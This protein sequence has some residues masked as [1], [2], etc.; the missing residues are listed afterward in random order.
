[1]N[2]NSKELLTETPFK[3]MLKLSVPAIIGMMVIGLYPLMDGIFAGQLLGQD[4]MTAIGVSMPFTYFNTG[5]ATLI[6]VGSS[7]ILSR[8]IGENNKDTF[9][10]IMNNLLFWVLILSL[11]ITILGFI[12]SK[13][14]LSL[15]GAEGTILDLANR[16]LTII[17]TGSLF[18][19]FAQSANMLLRGE[20]LMKKA[21]VIMT[22]GA[23]L[24][25]ILDPLLM[26]AMRNID[27]GIEGAAIATVLA[28][29][30][31][32]FVTYYYFKYKS[33]TIK[34]EK[35]KKEITIS[36]EVFAVGVSA[37]LMQVLTIIQQSILYS[38]AFRYG[39]DEAG[40]IMAATLRIMAFSFIPLWGMSQGLQ[41]AIGTNFG[42]KEYIR[43]KQLTN[44]FIIG[45]TCLA[46]FFFAIIEIFSVQILAA[47]IT[48]SSVVALGVSNFRL[49]Y[50]MFPTYGLLIMAVTY[51]QALGKAKQAGLLVTLRQ[52]AL[53]VPLV[54]ILPRI[55]NGR[56][57]GVWLALPVNDI[58]IILIAVILL[59]G[60][61]KQLAQ[62]VQETGLH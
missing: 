10:K 36:K 17:F 15:I 38:Q 59:I 29:I 8:A 4:A 20:G 37:M 9:K 62:L 60:E 35:I 57:L 42:A 52:F 24:N 53:A 27:R 56:V 33:K 12:F 18:V 54:L 46:G 22:L 34:I 48:D 3:I 41:P 32:A 16:Y 30:V 43:V 39:G 21:M 50:Y 26:I 6:G 51:F 2:T 1:M 47:F 19:N 31:Q 13:K 49:M 11:I 25:I 5:V 40:S 45:S 55:L 28:Q 44:V 58:I 7:S 23:G 61:Y 14:L